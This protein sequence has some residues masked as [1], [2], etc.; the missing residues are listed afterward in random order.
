M[1]RA[2]WKGVLLACGALLF[3][4]VG[5]EEGQVS[6]DKRSRVIAAENQ[7]LKKEI[8]QCR[9]QMEQLKQAHQREIQQQQ[10]QLAECRKEREELSK[11]MKGQI[12][13]Q[14]ED[15]LEAVLE[16][17]AKLRQENEQLRKRIAELESSAESKA[18][19]GAKQ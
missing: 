14:V 4:V 18:Q 17:N 3:G 7:A 5:C 12:Q 2:I 1:G 8:E 6:G 13:R 10:K 11:Q 9:Q 16:Q 19:A 15:V